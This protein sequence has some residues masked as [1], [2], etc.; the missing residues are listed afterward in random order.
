M[1]GLS[2]KV[3]RTYNA[4]IT[5]QNQFKRLRSK[6]KRSITTYSL[7]PSSITDTLSDGLNDVKGLNDTKVFR[8]AG[9]TSRSSSN[10][11]YSSL[12]T[13]NSIDINNIDD[14]DDPNNSD[15][16]N[17]NNADTVKHKKD[18]DVKD[19]CVD[20]GNVSELLQFYNYAN[21]EVAILCNHQRSIPKQHETSM[22]K[23]KLQAK[24]LK[25]DIQELNE[26]CKHLQSNSKGEFKFESKTKV[27][28]H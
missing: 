7:L 2:A 1:D 19:V 4:S 6:Y 5:L 9:T 27:I 15:A 13:T 22:T 23:L 10:T 25:E 24:M 18:D 11:D 20:I 21:R 14:L 26:Y 3:F 12:T 28:L 8:E 17:S 16:D